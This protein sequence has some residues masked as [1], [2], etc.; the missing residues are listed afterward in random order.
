MRPTKHIGTD[1]HSWSNGP[2]ICLKVIH[3][4]GIRGKCGPAATLPPEKV[5]KVLHF[6]KGTILSST[7]ITTQVI[8]LWSSP[9][10]PEILDEQEPVRFFRSIDISANKDR[11]VPSS[12][13][14]TMLFYLIPRYISD[15]ASEALQRL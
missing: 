4:T 5:T 9:I 1:F 10:L 12:R 3:Y 13:S 8:Q 2:Q 14:S 6:D 15:L 11:I 7:T